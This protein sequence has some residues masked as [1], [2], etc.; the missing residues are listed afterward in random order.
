MSADTTPIGPEP[1]LEPGVASAAA[2]SGRSRALL[3]ATVG[4]VAVVA[5]GLMAFGALGGSEPEPT[6]M[7]AQDTAD[8]DPPASEP[9]PVPDVE[10]LPVAYP[11]VTYDVY[12]AR[13]PFER[14]IPEPEP[15]IDDAVNGAPA[16]PTQPSD[17]AQPYGPGTALGPDAALGPHRAGRTDPRDPERPLLPGHTTWD[18]PATVSGPLSGRGRGGL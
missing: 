16:D 9:E 13:D 15:S 3:V 10:E 5:L 11:T 7:A 2:T 12:L 8:T 14:V 18:R 6:A 4:L 1:A 17:P